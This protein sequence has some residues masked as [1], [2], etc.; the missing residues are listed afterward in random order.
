MTEIEKLKKR[1]QELIDKA[2]QEKRFFPDEVYD[3]DVKIQ[4]LIEQ[5]EKENEI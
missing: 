4:K 1:N 5:K 2:N 3:N